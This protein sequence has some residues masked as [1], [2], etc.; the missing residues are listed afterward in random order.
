MIPLMPNA[1][2]FMR[3]DNGRPD[4]EVEIVSSPRIYEHLSL[5]ER[6]ASTSVCDRRPQRV[7]ASLL[8][9]SIARRSPAMNL[10]QSIDG[11]LY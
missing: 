2:T 10:L 3:L 1:R 6:G 11:D 5:S 8:R 7:G 4:D 9:L